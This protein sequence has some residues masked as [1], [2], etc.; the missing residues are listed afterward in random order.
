M[1][2]AASTNLV[3]LATMKQALGVDPTTIAWM[4][5]SARTQAY[6]RN[7]QSGTAAPDLVAKFGTLDANDTYFIQL[8]GQVTSGYSSTSRYWMD[9]SI[10]VSFL[11]DVAYV[12]TFITNAGWTWWSGRRRSRPRSRTTRRLSPGRRST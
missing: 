8:N 7:P 4:Y 3:T 12:D 10:G 2:N 6:G 9:P 11:D 5:A 1:T